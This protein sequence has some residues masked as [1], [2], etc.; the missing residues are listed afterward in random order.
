[1]NPLCFFCGK[2][3]PLGK[4]TTIEITSTEGFSGTGRSF[5]RYLCPKHSD[6]VDQF[7]PYPWYEGHKIV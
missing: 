5:K 1:M 4:G 7:K 2:I 3:V 6:Q